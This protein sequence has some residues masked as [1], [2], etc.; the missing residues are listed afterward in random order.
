MFNW[1]YRH[2][3]IYSTFV[4]SWGC[5]IFSPLSFFFAFIL[6]VILFCSACLSVWCVCCVRVP[7]YIHIVS[8]SQCCHLNWSPHWLPPFHTLSHYFALSLFFLWSVSVYVCVYE[9]AWWATR[10]GDPGN[11][12][13]TSHSIK[14]SSLTKQDRHITTTTTTEQPFTLFS[15]ILWAFPLFFKTLKS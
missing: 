8:L 2:R 3:S 11:S 7:T 13:K 14:C 12:P 5:F 10:S 9:R 6:L 1:I 4:P 15:S